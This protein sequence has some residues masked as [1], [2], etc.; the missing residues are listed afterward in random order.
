MEQRNVLSPY[1]NQRLG[2]E[3]VPIG[4][5]EPNR[6]NKYTYGVIFASVT[7]VNGDR[8][9]ELDHTV[10]KMTVEQ[11][12]KLKLELYQRYK[13]TAVI[14]T[15]NKTERVMGIPAIRKHYMLADINTRKVEPLSETAVIQPSIY[16][17]TRINSIVENENCL[18]TKDELIDIIKRIPNDG[19]VEHFVNNYTST[20]QKVEYNADDI[21]SILY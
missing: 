5:I 11:Y 4:F 15:Y 3:G 21:K 19:S 16:V 17:E 9:I 20:F 13:F 8:K 7:H 14:Q 1:L 12:D 10:I 2:F 18:Y 6:K